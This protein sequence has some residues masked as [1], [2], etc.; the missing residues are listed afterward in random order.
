M[1]RI[2]AVNDSFCN[3]DITDQTVDALIQAVSMHRG[4]AALDAL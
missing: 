4:S 2:L 3:G 1:T